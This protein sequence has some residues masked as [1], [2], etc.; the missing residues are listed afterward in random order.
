[1]NKKLILSVLAGSVLLSGI[2]TNVYAD[3]SVTAPSGIQEQMQGG[4]GMQRGG[5]MMQPGEGMLQHGGEMMQP[6]GG[7]GGAQNVSSEPLP[8]VESTAV[9]TAA[10]LEA[11]MTNARRI[12]VSDT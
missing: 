3:L 2:T 5:G 10:A 8:I 11:D 9:N 12:T 1:M 4:R 7:M 6:G